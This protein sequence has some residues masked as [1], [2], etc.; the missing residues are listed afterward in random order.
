M[1]IPK[2]LIQ[3]LL[4]LLILMISHQQKKEIMQ[5]SLRSN[6]VQRPFK[7]LL[8]A[9]MKA[10]VIAVIIL[11]GRIEKLERLGCKLLIFKCF[12]F[13]AFGK[14]IL[15]TSLPLDQLKKNVLFWFD[16]GTQFFLVYSKVKKIISW[17]K[18]AKV[19][20]LHHWCSSFSILPFV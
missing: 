12:K 2:I 16:C 5:I 9:K 19:R 13:A 20:S 14:K 4:I 6:D 15:A 11:K 8:K 3:I 17:S 10:F 1:G 18:V 7:I